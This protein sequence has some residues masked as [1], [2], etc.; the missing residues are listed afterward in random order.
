VSAGAHA[1]AGRSRRWAIVATL[2]VTETVSWGILYYAFAVFLTPMRRELGL[3]TAEIAGA[4]S[5][6]VLVSGL[7]GIAVGRWLDRHS[8]R[9]LMTGGSIAGVALVVAWSQVDGLLA[10][11]AIWVA[12]GFVMATVLYEPAFVVVAKWFPEPAER[13]RAMTAMTLVAAL[14]SF[15]F[16]PTSQALI[17]AYGWRHALLV[18][19]AILAVATVPL[20]GLVLRKP[21]RQRVERDSVMPSQALRTP[22]FWLLSGAFVL[23]S[24]A[25]IAMT[26]HTIPFLL[27]RGHSAAFAAFALGLIGISQ[28]PGR[29]LFGPLAGR[30]SPGAANAGVFLLVAVGIGL[31]VGIDST[32]TILAGLV[33]LGMGNGMATLA[34][35]V[36]IADHYGTAGYGA[37]AGVTAAMTTAAR[38]A[39]PVLAAVA[40]AATSYQTLLWL[41]VGIAATAAA[42][43]RAA[44]DRRMPAAPL[45]PARAEALQ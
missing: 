9:P 15:I 7:A 20:H 37:I 22:S 43:A 24:L 13:R 19:A 1:I 16:L 34:R 12:I 30:L 41:L 25:T 14:A 31:V 29:V 3:S 35:A 17:E 18:L 10:L 33:L 2:S 40:A 8:P 4:F 6:A 26:V 5:A 44:E 42:C 28:I 11:Y 39:A 27:E 32:G 23:A 21:D 38:A 36:T 45:K